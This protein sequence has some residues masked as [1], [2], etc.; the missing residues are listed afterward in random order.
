[1]IA[2]PRD[3]QTLED[4]RG[5]SV[6]QYVDYIKMSISSFLLLLIFQSTL[7]PKKSTIW[8]RYFVSSSLERISRVSP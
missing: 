8:K 3:T 5:W 1:M 4:L 2:S 6:R 7:E